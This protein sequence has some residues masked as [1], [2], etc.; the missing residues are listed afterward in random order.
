MFIFP[1]RIYSVGENEIEN[2]TRNRWVKLM[3]RKNFFKL[4]IVMC[5]AL[6]LTGAITWI[7]ITYNPRTV[8]ESGTNI[9]YQ[10]DPLVLEF[11]ITTAKD[12]WEI[13]YYP[14]ENATGY[15]V[16]ACWLL[17]CCHPG[18]VSCAN[19][20]MQ[21]PQVVYNPVSIRPNLLVY[22]DCP[23]EKE[24]FIVWKV[25]EGHTQTTITWESTKHLYINWNNILTY[26]ILGVIGL[27][28][29]GLVLNKYKIP[30]TLK[31]KIQ[32]RRETREILHEERL[33][34][35]AELKELE[36]KENV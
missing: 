29:L 8:Y 10:Y 24:L 19:A 26:A 22:N 25:W 31:K 5:S 36:K 16:S 4:I 3:E 14:V 21:L 32:E 17:S 35:I 15:V 1:F 34:A 33:K 11:K 23:N 18:D 12:Y 6:S 28:T 13:F 27:I 7:G 9:T 2:V 30:G 20:L